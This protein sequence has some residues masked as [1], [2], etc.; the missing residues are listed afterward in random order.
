L[1]IK[2]ETLN[3]GISNAKSSISRIYD[4]DMAWEQLSAMRGTILQQSATSMLAQL[5]MAPQQV[6]Q[7]FG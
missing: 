1:D 4:T 2:E 7:L 3:T 6:L 5:N